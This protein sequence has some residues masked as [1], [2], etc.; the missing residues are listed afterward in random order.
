M[1]I[2]SIYEIKMTTYNATHKKRILKW[3]EANSDRYKE[4]QKTYCSNYYQSN[5]SKLNAKKMRL[6]YYAQECKRMRQILFA[7]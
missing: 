1:S 2:V 4:L 7:E 6:Y 3:R 5:K